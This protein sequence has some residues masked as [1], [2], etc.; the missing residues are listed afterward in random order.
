[1]KKESVRAGYALEG[2]MLLSA[3][4][5]GS[6]FSSSCWT[7]LIKHSSPGVFSCLSVGV[8]A[9]NPCSNTGA[10]LQCTL[11]RCQI[12][13]TRRTSVSHTTAQRPPDDQ[14]LAILLRV[15]RAMRALR[16]RVVCITLVHY[17][18]HD[19]APGVPWCP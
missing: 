16:V 6:C 13:I 7:L 3:A 19:P 10:H 4:A 5:G 17:P 8:V 9:A 2:M 18:Q 14:P 11:V 12:Y 1:M 15:L